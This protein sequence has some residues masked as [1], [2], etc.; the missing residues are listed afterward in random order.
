MSP[1][2]ILRGPAGVAEA[3]VT[4][5]LRAVRGLVRPPGRPQGPFYRTTR[6]ETSGS[7]EPPP[8]QQLPCRLSGGV[9]GEKAI[10]AASGAWSKL[11]ERGDR[12]VHRFL[13][14]SFQHTLDG[15]GI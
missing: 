2:L 11:L 6:R 3:H 15:R 13:A 9:A 4:T 7:Y 8:P 14:L 1:R 12:E 5:M 10:S